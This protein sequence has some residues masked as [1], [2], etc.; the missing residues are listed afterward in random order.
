MYRLLTVFAAAF[1]VI[2]Q[3]CAQQYQRRATMVGGGSVGRGKCTIEVV[4]D[5][6][7]DVEIRG[8]QGTIRNISGS[9]AQWRRFECSAPLPASA[10]DFRFAGIDGRGR[11]QLV[12]DPRN[13]GVAVVRIEDPE[14]GSEGY[15]FDLIWAGGDNPG[16]ARGGNGS[17][18]RDPINIYG[19]DRAPDRD[20]GPDR[21]PRGF[22]TEQAVNTCQDAVR[23]QAGE[24]FGGRGIEFLNTRIDDNPGRKDWVVGMIDVLRGQ[25]GQERFRFSCSVNFDNGQVRSVQIDPMADR[26]R[27]PDY[28]PRGFTTEQAVNT[29][30][31][32]VRKQAGERFGGRGIEFLNTRIDDNPGRN[33]FVVGMIDVL[34]GQNGQERFSFSCSVNFDNG[35]VRSVQI[36]PMADR[37]RD[38]GPDYAPR[39]LNTGQA[40]NVC[41]D[42]V[43]RQALNRFRGRRVE[44]LNTRIDNN[45]GRN[46][47][48]VGMI[49]VIRGRDTAEGRYKFSCSVD[50]DSGQVRSAQIDP[51]SE[52]RNW[53]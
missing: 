22:T 10:A 37:D 42:A 5:G 38:R 44:F 48:V 1:I 34:H 29:C 31:D 13:G 11:Q 7:A 27:S 36:D 17:V 52:P 2:S 9:P 24:R 15:T 35:N 26:D 39:N 40:V 4:V 53:R 8:D 16:P 12:R 20:R 23:R 21:A 33:D 19:G 30:Q 46:D 50:F 41:Q 25:N 32:A 43:R 6:A 49:D 18:I 47:F 14:G 3:T 51:R 45:P 28:A